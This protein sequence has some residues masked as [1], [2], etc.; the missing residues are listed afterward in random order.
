[1]KKTTS[2]TSGNRRNLGFFVRKVVKGHKDE[3]VNLMDTVR[4]LRRA[5]GSCIWKYVAAETDG[6][7]SYVISGSSRF[8]LIPWWDR[9][10][11][12]AMK[13][14]EERDSVER[15]RLAVLNSNLD[16]LVGRVS[17]KISKI[18][19]HVRSIVRQIYVGLEEIRSQCGCAH[20]NL[21][22]SNIVLEPHD[23]MNEIVRLRLQDFGFDPEIESSTLE[24]YPPEIVLKKNKE[25]SYSHDI[26]SCGVLVLTLLGSRLLKRTKTCKN[27]EIVRSYCTSLNH[28]CSSSSSSS[29]SNKENPSLADVWL[30]EDL[31]RAITPALCEFVT[32][33]LYV[34]TVSRN[35]TLPL[36]TKQHKKQDIKPAQ[37]PLKSPAPPLATPLK[38]KKSD[39]VDMTTH[40]EETPLI[41]VTTPTKKSPVSRSPPSTTTTTSTTNT[42]LRCEKLE[43]EKSCLRAT[44]EG[45]V[46]A[47]FL[48][49]DMQ[50]ASWQELYSLFRDKIPRGFEGGMSRGKNKTYISLASTWDNLLQLNDDSN[51]KV[52]RALAALPWSRPILCTACGGSLCSTKKKD[53][54]FL[55]YA[56]IKS[57]RPV[58]VPYSLRRRVWCAF[59][60]VESDEDTVSTFSMMRNRYANLLCRAS[61]LG[62][63]CEEQVTKDVN[64]CHQYIYLTQTP[65]MRAA[66]TR[67]VKAWIVEGRLG[68]R[69]YYQGLSSVCVVF[70][71][72]FEMDEAFAFAC[73]RTF[74]ERHLLRPSSVPT[75]FPRS[76]SRSPTRSRSP[77]KDTRSPSK[78]TRVHTKDTSTKETPTKEMMRTPPPKS[79]IKR[80]HTKPSQ[81]IEEFQATETKC[82]NWWDAQDRM[83]FLLL[84][85]LLLCP[86]HHLNSHSK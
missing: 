21:L 55:L 24:F 64:R 79:R 81:S 54:T 82:N 78:D 60:D 31:R 2:T 46:L 37:F 34:R 83:C 14:E 7:F 65:T 85:L 23:E 86:L 9:V 19:R 50:C 42:T 32:T 77:S 80:M 27:M 26:W 43:N 58:H 17:G 22:P 1:M 69:G 6:K 16:V 52:R 30:D 33:S 56:S 73:L 3:V 28:A 15:R 68:T 12:G 66:V 47:P 41:R 51:S 10:V 48:P 57:L 75:R 53:S 25:S 4:V 11:C 76:P 63:D 20:G 18:E 67:L 35:A 70:L 72:L 45:N 44:L 8:E 38:T 39:I 71:V 61:Q 40:V 5:R 74:L 62:I 13:V 84:L 36:E 29:S 49:I 59:L